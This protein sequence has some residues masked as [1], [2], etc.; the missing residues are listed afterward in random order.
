MKLGSLSPLGGARLAGDPHFDWATQPFQRYIS[1]NQHCFLAKLQSV[2]THKGAPWEPKCLAHRQA[3]KLFS[4]LYDTRKRCGGGENSRRNQGAYQTED[5]RSVS[6]ADP[7]SKF[8]V[9]YYLCCGNGSVRA[10]LAIGL[11][12]ALHCAWA[13]PAAQL[14]TFASGCRIA[15][16][17]TGVSM[18]RSSTT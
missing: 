1:Q 3:P 15:L 17:S 7:E 14:A 13:T 2:S 10:A 16:H 6:S 12:T 9:Q 11:T 18:T 8:L 5:V 4:L